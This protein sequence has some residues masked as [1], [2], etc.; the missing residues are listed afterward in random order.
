MLQSNVDYQDLSAKSSLS[1]NVSTKEEWEVPL[2]E[3]ESHQFLSL[4]Q[5]SIHW[6]V[7]SP[8]L[9]LGEIPVS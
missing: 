6:Y 3:V 5:K 7:I 8:R 2:N 9:G 4:I 1:G